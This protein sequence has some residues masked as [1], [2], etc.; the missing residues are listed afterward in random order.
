VNDEALSFKPGE[1][2]PYISMCQA[3][4]ASLQRGMNFRLHGDISVVLMSVRKGAP[5]ADR[6]EDDAKTL[7]Y[8]GHDVS[9]T[10]N[11]P[12]PKRV[13]QPR[14]LP[15]GKITQNGLFYEAAIKTK[16]GEARPEK[17]R[18]YD[19]IRDGVWTFAGTFN[20]VDARQEKVGG[21]KVF[22]FK[23]TVTD[24]DPQFEQPDEERDLPHNRLIP[25]AVKIDVWKRD[26]GKCIQ[27][28]SKD[29]LHFDHNIPFS[30]GGS[31]LVAKNIQLLCARHNL[32]K[33]AKII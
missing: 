14:A 11:G 18:V 24:D 15:S 27:C 21:R 29:N 4:G 2:I 22:K 20:L 32:S 28:G 30:L 25:T 8:E 12:N 26:G 31:S 17:V 16:N 23:L 6:I 7:I 3:E 33:R 5:Y 13:N 19:K 1:V 10:K 9:R